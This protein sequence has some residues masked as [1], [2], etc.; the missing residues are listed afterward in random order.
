MTKYLFKELKNHHRFVLFFVLNLSLGLS[1]FVA[2]DFFKHSLDV[3]LKNKSKAMLGGDLAV[4]ARRAL[5]KE[6]V[7]IVEQSIGVDMEEAKIIQMY[8]MLAGANGNSRLVHIQAITN[9]YPFYGGFQF[10][11]RSQSRFESQSE[12][13]SRSQSESESESESRSESE[14]FDPQI[15]IH[16]E[17][18]VWVYPELLEQLNL[19]VGD[20]VSIGQFSFRIS[21]VV[22]DDPSGNL[23]NSVAPR[24]YISQK[25]L[26][27]TELLG[28][29]SSAWHSYIYKIPNTNIF[30]LEKISKD[31]FS[32]LKD[33]ALRVYTHQDASANITR[34]TDYLNDFLSLVAL[35]AL[36]LACVGMGFLL[37]SYLKSK[38]REMA[39]LMTLGLSRLKTFSLYFLQIIVLGLV[40][41]FISV[42]LGFALFIFLKPIFINLIPFELHLRVG[43]L[44]ISV[45]LAVLIPVLVSLPLFLHIRNIKTSLLLRE[46][47][48]TKNRFSL[49]VFLSFLLGL[50]VFWIL[51]VWQSHSFYMGSVFTV[52]FLFSGASLFGIGYFTLF[53]FN[54]YKIFSSKIL[55]WSIRDLC[56]YR[57]SSLVC[58]LCLS[59]GILLLNLIPQ[60]QGSL[61]HEIKG[62]EASSLPSLFLYDIQEHQIEPLKEI[63]ISNEIKDFTMMPMVR[64]RLLS[65]NNINF[66]KGEGVT[67]K[68]LTRDQDRE[69][70]FRNRGFNLSYRSYMYETEKT[71]KGEEFKGTYQSENFQSSGSNQTEKTVKGEEFKGTYQSESSQSSGSNQEENWP[72][73]SIENRFAKRLNFQVNDVLNFDVQGESVKGIVKNIRRV[74]WHTFQPNFFVLFQS[75][76]L[77]K[78]SKTYVAA[79]PGF[80]NKKITEIQNSI[81]SRLPN[82]SI[83]NIRRVANKI[84]ALSEQITKAL[85]IMSVLCLLLGFVVL[86]S[87][88]L[89]QVQSRKKDMALF[90]VLGLSALNLHKLFLYQFALITLAAGGLGLL[91]SLGVSYVISV[92]FFHSSWAFSL[93]L[94]VAILLGAMLLACLL[95]YISTKKAIHTPVRSLFEN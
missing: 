25:Y 5:T 59:L 92:L 4:S 95:T 46:S 24:V 27:Q 79:L 56:R 54:R 39:I 30:Q 32:H 38:V 34:L 90:K 11:S 73:I 85:Q 43:T 93:S 47:A 21:D 94:P 74:K 8:S 14:S 66:D 75:G 78:F 16:K 65:V 42:I 63:L 89:H 36:V 9:N 19:Q 12:S 84:F 86:Y 64:A 58:F 91:S 33:P 28:P 18:V 2:L 45:L 35:C 26:P 3:V 15:S 52:L 1:G 62:P 41:F 20:K 50:F 77:E 57:T 81:V 80:S 37:Y 22:E 55:F 48:D 49:T 61:L 23:S 71:V 44:G 68:R 76:V 31:I 70:H 17:P 88:A 87:V 83:V 69:M 13:E 40:S 82:I 72:W 7:Q 60:I 6:E 53:I 29:Y 67:G 51:A 10:R